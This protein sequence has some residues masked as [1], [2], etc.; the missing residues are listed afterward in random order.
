[1]SLFYS[2]VD[3]YASRKIIDY[4]S[5]FLFHKK[6]TTK[7]KDFIAGLLN[8]IAGLRGGNQHQQKLLLLCNCLK[9]GNKD[10]DFK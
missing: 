5:L 6:R 2:L 7:N 10:D 9:K 4:R 3:F 8:Q 1:M